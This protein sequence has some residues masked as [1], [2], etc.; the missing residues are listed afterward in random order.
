MAASDPEGS[1]LLFQLEGGPAGA[2]V[3]PAGLLIWSVS[4]RE[5]EEEEEEE[6]E[7][8]G[9]RMVRFTLSDEC[10]AQ[11]SHEVEVRRRS[12]RRWLGGGG[13]GGGSLGEG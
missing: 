10:S 5:E 3:S 13:G 2:S 7:G 1:A 11:S 9:R 12:S 4:P 8:D 6:E